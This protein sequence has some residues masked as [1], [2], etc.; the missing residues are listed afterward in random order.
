[1]NLSFLFKY[2]PTCICLLFI[3]I[4]AEAQ[5]IPV[6]SLQ[7][8]Q[9]RVLQLLSDSTVQTSF[10]DRSIWN[11]TYQK[12]F[13]RQKIQQY[14]SSWWAKPLSGYEKKL[15]RSWRYGLYTPIIRSTF[16]S[17]LPYGYNNGSAWYGRGFNEEFMGGFYVTSKYLTV[18]FR[19]HISYSQNTNFPVPRFI[20]RDKN[21][22]P[23]YTSIMGHRID[24][25]FRFGPNSFTDFNLGLTS[26]SIH[27]KS[28]A[29]G[30]SNG[31]L[32]WGPGVQNALMLSNNAAGLK[33]MFFGT[34]EPL[35]IPLGIGALEFKIIWA[36]PK[37]SKYFHGNRKTNRQR[38]GAGININYSPGFAPNLSLGFTRF[39]WRYIPKSGLEARAFGSMLPFFNHRQK[40]NKVLYGK[41]QQNQMVSIYFRWAFPKAGAEV[42]GEYYREDSYSNLRDLYFE[43][44]HD[45]AY[46]IGFQKVVESHGWFNLFL[47]NGEINNL[48]PDRISAVRPQTYMYTHSIIQQGHTNQGQV[49]GASIGP[50]SA[51]EYLGIKGFFKRGDIGL[52]VQR[53]AVN[54]FFMFDYY[55]WH[56]DPRNV[57]GRIGA[58]DM[59]R[60]RINLNIGLN[61]RYKLGPLMLGARLVRNKNFNYGR[62]NYGKLKGIDFSNVPK[63]D[64]VNIQVQ[65]SIR[66]NFGNLLQ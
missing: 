23:K 24:M 54:D 32:W 48:V 61:G 42:Y 21:G 9:Y 62:Y 63:N 34:R 29:A 58:K 64:I 7:E 8:Q 52:F 37:D 53:V 36:E 44:D 31:T 3:V 15:S 11:R 66:Y 41:D 55:N 5:P 4:K 59:W 25:P 65:L 38:F 26:V 19:P 50:G 49:L 22:N 30:F 40:K 39:S 20:P 51:D 28:I 17:Q 57:H 10:D 43:P 35:N 45:R 47:I 27:Y 1:M 46:T 14:S 12:I 60:H 56:R 2:L 16:N 33:H 6:G 13:D 18:T